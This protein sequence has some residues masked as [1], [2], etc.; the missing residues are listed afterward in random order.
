MRET[1]AANF[2][3]RGD[4]GASA[5]VTIDGKLAVD[6]WGGW[7]DA[8][9]TFPWQRDTVT[10][11]A[12]TTKTMTALAALLLADRGELDLDAPVARYWPAFSQNGKRAVTTAQCL[13]HTAGVPGWSEP[14][15]PEDLFDWQKCTTLLARE[16]PW[17][18][19]GTASGYHALTQGY[20]VGEVIRRI[21]GETP[22]RFFAREFAE[23]LAADFHIGLPQ[24]CDARLAPTIPAPD[25][26]EVPPAPGSIAHRVGTNPDFQK[27][28][29]WVEFLRAEIPAANGVGNARAVAQ[30][31]SV[32]ATG[33]EGVGRRILSREGAMR[34]LT[35]QSDGV[36]RVF[37]SPVRFALGYAL[38]LGPLK[39]GRGRSCFW[40]GAGGH[41][42]VVDFEERMT[43]AYVMNKSVG[44]P[45]GDP[46]NRAIV[47]AVYESLGQK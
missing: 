46:R 22:G 3:E 24:E 11:T 26:N 2:S 47:N 45:F 8:E 7:R 39:F 42:I 27:V 15:A 16:A 13:G 10:L 43:I 21:T 36:D 4:I 23:P 44:V 33:G 5:A 20:L 34:V 25:P 19:P 28:K 35:Q 41:L 37:A 29:N 14:M 30:I 6:L 38:A 17:W 12:S 18:A 32:L 40:G 31:Q 1:F 9:K